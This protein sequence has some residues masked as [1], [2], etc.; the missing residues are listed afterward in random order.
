MIHGPGPGTGTHGTPRAGC[1]L[2]LPSLSA[3]NRST[4]L[5]Q[6]ILSF[7]LNSNGRKNPGGTTGSLVHWQCGLCQG[8]ASLMVAVQAPSD[9]DHDDDTRA[10]LPVSVARLRRRPAR[11]CQPMARPPFIRLRVGVR[12]SRLPTGARSESAR[13]IA[14]HCT[15]PRRAFKFK[16]PH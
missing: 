7:R 15:R 10:S 1:R 11:S 2:Q 3:F 4:G 6:V 13:M 16:L 5:L 8:G 9:D 14:P 12:T